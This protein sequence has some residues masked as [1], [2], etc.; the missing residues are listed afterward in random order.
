MAS[1]TR[2]FVPYKYQPGYVIQTSDQW[3]SG[4]QYCVL[5]DAQ[6]VVRD[7]VYPKRSDAVTAMIAEVNELNY[8]YGRRQ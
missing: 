3:C 4:W 8:I 7:T 2:M 1:S 6:I 5:I